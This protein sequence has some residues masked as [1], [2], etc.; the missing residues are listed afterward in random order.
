MKSTVSYM[1]VNP[2]YSTALKSCTR[3]RWWTSTCLLEA[4]WSP[5]VAL[6]LSSIRLLGSSFRDSGIR[7]FSILIL[8]EVYSNVGW[9]FKGWLGVRSF[10]TWFFSILSLMHL[11][12][13]LSFSTFIHIFIYPSV[14]LFIYLFIHM[15]KNLFIYVFLF[16]LFDYIYFFSIYLNI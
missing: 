11:F 4:C 8:R 1:C 13:N 16:H 12:I 6:D 9:W 7:V 3:G 2:T 15:F 14:H 5:M 10:F